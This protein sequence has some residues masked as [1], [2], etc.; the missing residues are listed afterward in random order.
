MAGELYCTGTQWERIERDLYNWSQRTYSAHDG[1]V[2]VPD[3]SGANI[4]WPDGVEGDLISK[5][6]VLR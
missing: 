1:M 3:M 2:G 6:R 5:L 4:E